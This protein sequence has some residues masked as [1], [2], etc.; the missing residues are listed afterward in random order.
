MQVPL[1]QQPPQLLHVPASEP[2]FWQTPALQICEPL[3]GMHAAP[4]FPQFAAV[5]GETQVFPLQ[6]PEQVDAH[7]PASPAIVWHWPN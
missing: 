4:F 1:A 2:V 3:H 7:V 6:H 5:A